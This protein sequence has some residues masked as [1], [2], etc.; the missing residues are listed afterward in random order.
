[1]NISNTSASIEYADIAKKLVIRTGGSGRGT[2]WIANVLFHPRN[3]NIV[4]ENLRLWATNMAALVQSWQQNQYK[5]GRIFTSYNQNIISGSSEFV[6]EVLARTNGRKVL[7]KGCDWPRFL[8]SP[9][10][11]FPYNSTCELALYSYRKDICQTKLEVMPIGSTRPATLY[12]SLTVRFS[13]IFEPPFTNSMT[14]PWTNLSLKAIFEYVEANKRLE[15]ISH[16]PTLRPIEKETPLHLDYLSFRK[17]KIRINT[18]SI[19]S[20]PYKNKAGMEISV[21]ERLKSLLRGRKSIQTKEFKVLDFGCIP[22]N[23]KINADSVKSGDLDFALVLPFL[24]ISSF[25]L[26]FLRMNIS[27]TTSSIEYA[28]IAEKLV[29]RVSEVD[30][31]TLERITDILFDARNKNIVFENFHLEAESMAALVQSWQENHYEIGRVF[32]SHCQS[33]IIGLPGFVEDVLEISNGQK[34]VLKSC[35]WP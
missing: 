23:L 35:D 34:V 14:K 26:K 19:Q 27:N 30:R 25:P 8:Y 28:D 3:Q 33:Q 5:V 21:A 15:I 13:P 18:K 32:T 17:N 12:R 24:H 11:T 16:C 29:I 1:M 10:I 2:Q 4:F 20:K 31:G 7:I 9:C 6:E 22:K